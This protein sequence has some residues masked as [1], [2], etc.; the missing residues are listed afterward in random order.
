[1]ITQSELKQILHYDQYTGIFTWLKYKQRPSKI[2][3]VAGNITSYKYW[4]I[5][6]NNKQYYAHRLAWLYMM[7]S[8]P[9]NAL[10]HIDANKLNNAFTNLRE[11]TSA[12]N[13]QNFIKAK[14]TNKAQLLGVNV[15]GKRFKARIGIDRKVITIGT[16]NTA[17]EAH[18]A[19]LIAKRKLHEFCTI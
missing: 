11:C 13:S 1:M 9:I 15:N 10:D 17:Q 12:Q 19:Y 18:N 5:C 8:N 6:I 2:G 14:I 16:F 4:T 3:A 7:G